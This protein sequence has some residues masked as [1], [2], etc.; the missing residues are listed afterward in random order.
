MKHCPTIGFRQHSRS[1]Y[2]PAVTHSDWSAAISFFCVY[3]NNVSPYLRRSLHDTLKDYRPYIGYADTTYASQFKAYLSQTLV[4]AYLKHGRII[5]Q[6]HPDDEPPPENENM[7]R[8]G[9]RS[10]S[11]R[12]RFTR[13]RR[14]RR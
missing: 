14:S 8:S 1:T 7:R 13:G 12:S 11:S 5:L 10:S 4:P 2:G 9:P 6:S 3:L